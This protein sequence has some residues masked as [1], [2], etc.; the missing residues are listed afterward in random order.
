[1]PEERAF[2]VEEFSNAVARL[3]QASI[4]IPGGCC[5]CTSCSPVIV[6][7][8]GGEIAELPVAMEE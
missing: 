2:D 5:C 7:G 4:R 8:P 1:M 3:V 6:G